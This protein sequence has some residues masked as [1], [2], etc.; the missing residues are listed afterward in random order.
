MEVGSGR[1][2]DAVIGPEGLQTVGEFDLLEGLFAG[3][4]RGEGVVVEG[5]PVL[6]EDDVL[7][8]LRDAVDGVD[9]GIAVGNG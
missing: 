2:L 3:V 4:G 8:M 6:G 1:A 5:V 9:D 7:E